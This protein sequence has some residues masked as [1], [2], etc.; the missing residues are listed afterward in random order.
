MQLKKGE[1]L[2]GAG[3]DGCG[4]RALSYQAAAGEFVVLT[5]L[6]RCVID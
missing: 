3:V 1:V 2:V 5:S 4:C 6:C